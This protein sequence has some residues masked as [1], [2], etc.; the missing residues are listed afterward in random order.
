M[1][2]ASSRFSIHV[3]AGGGSVA[4]SDSANMPN[5]KPNVK[6][7]LTT[8]ISS[9]HL[10]V[11]QIDTAMVACIARF[12]HRARHASNREGCPYPASGPEHK[13]PPTGLVP[14]DGNLNVRFSV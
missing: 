13:N 6:M 3:N 14:I 10:V 2:R 8:F 1:A 12:V 11:I 4:R 5:K 7:L 9:P